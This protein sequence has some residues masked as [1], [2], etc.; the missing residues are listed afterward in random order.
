MPEETLLLK[1]CPIFDREDETGG[2]Q[3]DQKL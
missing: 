1:V 3:K 2:K